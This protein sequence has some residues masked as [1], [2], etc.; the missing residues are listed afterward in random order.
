[1]ATGIDAPSMSKGIT[2]R[3]RYHSCYCSSVVSILSQCHCDA[4]RG[5]TLAN[6]GMSTSCS[7]GCS[8]FMPSS[9]KN[10]GPLHCALSLSLSLSLHPSL[11]LSLQV[12][13]DTCWAEAACF[14]MS[15]MHCLTDVVQSTLWLACL[16]IPSGQ[17]CLLTCI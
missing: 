12:P 8:P 16:M 7:C 9:F 1:M 3:C 13:L 5:N 6:C 4:Y 15:Q 10:V 2:G 17:L 11:C 14:N